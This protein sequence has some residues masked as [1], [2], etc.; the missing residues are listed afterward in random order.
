MTQARPLEESP[1]RGGPAPEPPAWPPRTPMEERAIA[2]LP[3]DDFSVMREF[4]VDRLGFAYQWGFTDDGKSGMMGLARGGME[5]TIDCPM[6]GH[7]REVCV[8]LRV[9]SADAYYAEWRE[10]V[11]IRRAPM[12]EEWGARTFG[13]SDPAGNTVFVIGPVTDGE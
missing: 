12:N 3:G 11:E 6:S 7:G 8:S 2:L 9:A 4:Y 10:K 13:F 1:D 5:L